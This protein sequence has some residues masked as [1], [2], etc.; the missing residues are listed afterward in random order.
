MSLLV[1]VFCLAGS[2]VAIH[3][4]TQ[5]WRASKASPDD[6]DTLIRYR[7]TVDREQWIHQFPDW[8]NYVLDRLPSDQWPVPTRYGPQ[9][10][11]LLPGDPGT[12]TIT[13]FSM[14]GEVRR[15]VVLP[16]LWGKLSPQGHALEYCA[17][18]T[19]LHL[20]AEYWGRKALG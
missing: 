16:D 19:C 17:C 9:P 6:V 4:L 15:E 8:K 14:G 11:P 13:L 3:A 7:E 12:K 18:T 1:L 2:G 5:A 10:R 20:R